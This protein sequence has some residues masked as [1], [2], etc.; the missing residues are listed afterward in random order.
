M[1]A[2]KVE[3]LWR[4]KDST[5]LELLNRVQALTSALGLLDDSSRNFG[6]EQVIQQGP[7][8]ADITCEEYILTDAGS[9]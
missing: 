6:L 8:L 1:E 3:L 4:D 5:V 7:L 2:S 9:I